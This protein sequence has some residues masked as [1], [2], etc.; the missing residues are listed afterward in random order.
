MND[1]MMQESFSVGPL[2]LADKLECLFISSP[3]DVDAHVESVAE[4]SSTRQRGQQP[5]KR[6]WAGVCDNR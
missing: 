5:A 4:V 3:L 2:V 1:T 6:V